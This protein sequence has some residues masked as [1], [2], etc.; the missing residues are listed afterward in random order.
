MLTETQP[1]SIHDISKAL[2]LTN[3]EISS[4]KSCISKLTELD[5]LRWNE[6]NC[7]EVIHFKERQEVYPSDI[8]DKSEITPSSLLITSDKTPTEGEGRGERKDVEVEGEKTPKGGRKKRPNP[9]DDPRVK[10]IIDEVKKFFG[11]PEKTDKDPIPN[12]GMEG[13][14]IKRMLTRRFTR[15]EILAC[16]RSKVSR[17]GGEYVSMKWVNQDIGNVVRGGEALPASSTGSQN[18]AMTA[19][20][21]STSKGGR[22]EI[23]GQR[24]SGARPASDFSGDKPW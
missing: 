20:S 22:R 6:H 16:W 11:Y 2:N 24:A 9:L 12:Y 18:Q 3:R 10:E 4:L 8:P 13:Q 23:K 14:A 17:R 1:M 7:L 5:S 19:E 21:G 15:E